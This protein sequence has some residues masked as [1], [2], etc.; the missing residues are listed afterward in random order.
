MGLIETLRSKYEL[1]RLEQRYTK[2][3]K[4]TTF[5]S[6][7]HYIDGEY[8][9]DVSPPSAKSSSSFGSSAM[10]AGKNRM[11]TIHVKE[12]FSNKRQSRAPKAQKRV[13]R[14]MAA[15]YSITDTVTT[16]GWAKTA[17]LAVVCAHG[18]PARNHRL[19]SAEDE[20]SRLYG[21]D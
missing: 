21:N 6:G 1:Y 9:Y 10:S 18:S 11:S 7:A 19:R 17:S 12:V 15:S 20:K 4:R 14:A 2:R 3:E 16:N 13:D 8:R 5:I